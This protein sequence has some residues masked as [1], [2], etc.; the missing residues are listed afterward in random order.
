MVHR[1]VSCYGD[2]DLSN[3][4]DMLT[5]RIKGAVAKNQSDAASRR[6]RRKHL[7]LAQDGK[8]NGGRRPYGYD[9]TIRDTDGVIINRDRAYKAIMPTEAA[10]IREAAERVLAGESLRSVMLDWNKKGVPTSHGGKLWT[11]S[12]L[13][14]VLVSP[15]IAGLREHKGSRGC[16]GQ[17]GVPGGF[18]RAGRRC[19]CRRACRSPR[20]LAVGRPA[21]RRSGPGRS[22]RAPSRRRDPRVVGGSG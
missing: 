20:P 19:C 17:A 5:L 22:G 18:G 8:P 2:T 21:R 12:N 1:L 9:G 3:S 7:E 13:R 6:L 10:R 15:R 4:D 14:R 16:S 11:Q